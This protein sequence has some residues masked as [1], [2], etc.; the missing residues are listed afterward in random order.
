M[1]RGCQPAW[2]PGEGQASSLPATQGLCSRPGG[3]LS[4]TRERAHEAQASADRLVLIT[5]RS[6]SFALSVPT[7]ALTQSPRESFLHPV[8][9]PLAQKA[10]VPTGDSHLPGGLIVS[11]FRTWPASI[12]ERGASET[13]PGPEPAILTPGVKMGELPR[14]EPLQ[15]P[16]SHWRFPNGSFKEPPFM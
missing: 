14:Q 11:S 12:S 7:N 10:G 16:F 1:Q 13:G 6:V 5:P 3:Q 15:P 4:P 8:S 2:V 9:A